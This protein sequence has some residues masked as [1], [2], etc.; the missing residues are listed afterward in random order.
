[1]QD[2]PLK[3]WQ[4]ENPFVAKLVRAVRNHA[5]QNFANGKEGWHIVA[6]CFSDGQIADIVECCGTEK[7]AIKKVK[8]HI[9]PLA[10]QWNEISSTAF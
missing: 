10:D 4:R 8:S 7:G 6:E 3:E 2:Q 5:L 1:M 9:K